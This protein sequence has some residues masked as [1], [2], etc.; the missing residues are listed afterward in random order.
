VEVDDDFA[1]ND[2][3][4][5]GVVV[6]FEG[7]DVGGAADAHEGLVEVGHFRVADDGEGEFADTGGGDERVGAA[8]EAAEAGDVRLADGGGDREVE[9]FGVGHGRVCQALLAAGVVDG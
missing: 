6:E 5:A 1:G 9:G 4:G 3:A 7:E 8:E 2:A